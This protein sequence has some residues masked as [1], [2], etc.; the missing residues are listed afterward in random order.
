MKRL[1]RILVISD[2][3]GD[4]EAAWEA[5]AQFHP[6]VL[7][8]CGDWGDPD[9]VS[10]AELAAFPAR[11]PVYTT[12]GNHDPLAVLPRLR[13]RDGSAM[14]LGQGD[15]CCVNGVRLAAIGGIWAKSHRKPHYVT[16]EDVAA[17]AAQIARCRPVDLLL[18][19]GCPV[20][21]ADLTP[22]GNHGG[23]R[24][25]LDAFRTVAPRVHF[26]G[27]LHV[28]QERTLKDGRRVINVGHTPSGSVAVVEATEEGISARLERFNRRS[29]EAAPDQTPAGQPS[30]G[31][32]P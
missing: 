32:K 15:V 11:L 6:D 13:N 30:S 17:F 9:Q 29:P 4:L 2:L 3:H 25:F 10:E 16:D 14:L 21:L 27:H 22:Q 8:S 20:G 26:C 31:V 19:H 24:C 18:T 5:L 7:L 28:P 23:Q 1:V 12:F